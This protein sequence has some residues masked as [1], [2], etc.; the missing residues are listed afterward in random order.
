MLK[1]EKAQKMKEEGLAEV[2]MPDGQTLQLP[3]LSDAAGAK[4]LDVRKL[5]PTTGMCTFDPGFTSTGACQ[6]QITFID[7]KEGVLVYRGYSIDDLAEK[8]DFTD[9]TYLLLHGELPTNSQR[10][11]FEFELTHHSLVHEQLIKFF[12][13]F[14]HDAHPMAIMVGVVGALAAFYS[15]SADIG[16]PA[17]RMRSCL[18]LIA[19]MPTLAAI[20]YKTSIGQ[21][22]VYPRNDL[23][24]SEN[25]LHML[26]SVPSEKYVMDPELARAMEIILVLHMDHEQ[27]ASTSTVRTA[28]SSQAN[29][30]ACIASGIAALWGPAHGGANEAVLRMLE[31]IGHVENIPDALERAKDKNDPFRLMGFGH[32]VYKTYDPRAKIMRSVC[33][34]VLKAAKKEN[35]PLL[36]IAL[37]LENIATS[38]EY[39]IKRGLYPNVDFYSGITLRAMGIPVSM[40]TVL[41]AV[42]RT[43]GWVSQWKEMAEDPVPRI[44]RP[45]Q[46]YLGSMKRN[47][48]DVESRCTSGSAKAEQEEQDRKDAASQGVDLQSIG[49]LSSGSTSHPAL[50]RSSLKR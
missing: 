22:I 17:E 2:K 27:N 21:P 16:N 48:V 32:R 8:G 24:Y 6:S 15:D 5:Q 23:S 34:R 1:F 37:E 10:E 43:V 14:K 38:D 28:G 4:F 25:F 9:A 44:S 29:P 33:H 30:F 3:V 36:K 41:F 42:A 40:Y 11:K 13:G 35:D 31:V 47:F 39:F 7:G 45:R 19:K 12:Q 20:A 50:S 46:M 49:R 18:R 26:F